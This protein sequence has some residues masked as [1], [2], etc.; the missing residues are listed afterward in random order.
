[1]SVSESERDRKRERQRDR[2]MHVSK[3]GLRLAAESR[4]H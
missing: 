1:M 2:R 4:C 3:C